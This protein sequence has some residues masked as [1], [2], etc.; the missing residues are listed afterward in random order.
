MV[1][2]DSKDNSVELIASEFPEVEIIQ[3]GQN[4][5]FAGGVNVGAKASNSEYILLLNPDTVILDGAIDKLFEY[6]Q[7][8]PKAGVWGG[9]TL[10]NDLSLNPNNAR[11]RLSFKTLLFSALGLSKAFNKSCFFNHDNYGCWDRKSE[12]E[13]D[14]VTGCFF[15]TPRHLWTDLQGLDETF[16]MYAEEADYCIRA[17]KKEGVIATCS[18]IVSEEGRQRFDKFADVI[19]D[20]GFIRCHFKN[21]EIANIK[22]AEIFISAPKDIFSLIKIKTRARLGNMELIAKN[23]CPVQEEKHYGNVMKE[24]LFKLIY[25]TVDI[26]IILFTLFLGSPYTNFY[27]VEGYLIAGLSAVVIFGLVG[28]FTDIYT[29]WSGRPLRDEALRITTAWRDY[30]QLLVIQYLFY[31]AKRAIPCTSYKNPFMVF[32][33]KYQK[34]PMNTNSPR[35]NSSDSNLIPYPRDF[36]PEELLE[37]SGGLDL[38]EFINVLKNH[39]KLILSIALAT[40][41]IALLLT[42]LDA[43]EA[44]RSD[45]DF[46]ETQIQLIQTKT[47]ASRVINELGLDKKPESAGLVSSL[48]NLITGNKAADGTDVNSMEEIFLKNL[49]NLERRFDT[50]SSY[51]TYVSDNI[52]VTKKSLEEAEKRLNDYAR[53]NNIVQDVD[54]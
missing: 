29:S 49:I 22:G 38:K 16:F 27:N 41:L 14:V 20:D 52:E 32:T 9:I 43:T 48:K 50:A 30:L 25:R 4:L 53:E 31:L 34:L 1:D 26:L 6:A 19:G 45:R 21:K 18:F 7:S 40:M 5:G 24:R 33:T 42:L 44:S 37:D 36:Y 51:K 28:R 12:R 10:N 3:T 2:N 17:I 46:F 23:K 11:A 15:L 47:L 54:G 35:S 39:K 8:T 13:V